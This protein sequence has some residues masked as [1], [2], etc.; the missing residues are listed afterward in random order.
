MRKDFVFILLFAVS[1]ISGCK[2]DNNRIATP[3]YQLDSIKIENIDTGGAISPYFTIP[4]S[5]S[6]FDS[7]ISQYSYPNIYGTGYYINND[8]IIYVN[9]PEFYDLNRAMIY[10]KQPISRHLYTP[11]GS[12][13][14]Y[15]YEKQDINYTYD[16]SVKLNSINYLIK[17]H[18][19][20]PY[21]GDSDYV[22]KRQLNFTYSNNTLTGITENATRSIYHLYDSGYDSIIYPVNNIG[23]FMYSSNF[24]NQIDMIGIDLND[25]IFKDIIDD[26]TNL[27]NLIFIANQR[28]SYHAKSS[29]LIEHF[30]FKEYIESFNQYLRNTYTVQYTFDSSRNNRVSTMSVRRDAGYGTLYTFYYRD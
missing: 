6:S 17:H 13:S 9:H 28:L 26:N 5:Q 21:G 12:F 30:E 29:L 3:T 16:A 7:F 23:T 8:S 27:G 2:K 1:I 11:N 10:N 4:V 18:V 24:A 15:G 20:N 25:L 14:Q 19:A 22:H